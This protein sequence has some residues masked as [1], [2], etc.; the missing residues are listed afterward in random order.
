MS[1]KATIFH[2]EVSGTTLHE[3]VILDEGD[4]PVYLRV[5][6]PTGC[7]LNS[8]N[9]VICNELQLDPKILDQLAVAWCKHRGLQGMPEGPVGREYGG[10]DCEYE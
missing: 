4:S 10:P 5:I 7:S 8:E 2:D 6:N 3:E 1:T 9:G